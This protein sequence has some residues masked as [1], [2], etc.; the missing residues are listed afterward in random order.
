M[1]WSEDFYLRAGWKVVRPHDA[2]RSEAAKRRFEGIAML[3]ANPEW[4]QVPGPT[5]VERSRRF[6]SRRLDRH[7]TREAAKGL[8]QNT[9]GFFKLLRDLDRAA[10]RHRQATVEAGDTHQRASPETPTP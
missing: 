4:A 10:S 8:I 2:G 3:P 1:S 7:L 6:W 9:A 5:F